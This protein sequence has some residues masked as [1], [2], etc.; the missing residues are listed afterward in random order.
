MEVE[1]GALAAKGPVE[2]G[3]VGGVAVPP[4]M[5]GN[6]RLQVTWKKGGWLSHVICGLDLK[7]E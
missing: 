7:G 6:H 5:A 1:G 3:G 2:T 4:S